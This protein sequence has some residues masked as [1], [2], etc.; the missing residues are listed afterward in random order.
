MFAELLNCFVNL[1]EVLKLRAFNN[2]DL[3][4]IK[5]DIPMYVI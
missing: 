4:R 1:V 3:I 2:R 5:N